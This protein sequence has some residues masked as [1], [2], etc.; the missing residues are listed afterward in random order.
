MVHTY[1]MIGNDPCPVG[2]PGHYVGIENLRMTREDR[3]NPCAHVHDFVGAGNHIVMVEDN[4]IIARGAGLRVV[5]KFSGYPD[6][7][8]GHAYISSCGCI[9]P[10]SRTRPLKVR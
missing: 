4:V 5:G 3:V 10:N 9:R 8:L 6:G 2:Q 7:G 1:R